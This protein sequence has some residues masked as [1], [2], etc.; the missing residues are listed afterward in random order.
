MAS[1]IPENG[2]VFDY[3]S[4]APSP[5]KDFC[6][7]LITKKEM[8]LRIW[9][10]TRL[11]EIN[12]S[13]PPP[14]QYTCT[15]EDF[16][17]DEKM[18]SEIHR[19]FGKGMVEYVHGITQGRLD[20]LPRLENDIALRIIRFLELEDIAHLA[21]VSKHFRDLCS[22][23][24]LWEKIYIDSSETPVT[25]EL[26]DLAEKEGWKKLF[27]TN[28]LQLQVQLRRQA[29]KRKLSEKGEGLVPEEAFM[30]ENTDE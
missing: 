18:Q 23:N 25:D 30:T 19:V 12:L 22:S 7:I 1:L 20:Y 9:K 13:P 24:E 16:D 11:S 10:I 6:Q 29:R 5:C 2:V 14:A 27:F 26:R 4:Q 28:K 15:F 3:S 21:Q 8:I 17:Y